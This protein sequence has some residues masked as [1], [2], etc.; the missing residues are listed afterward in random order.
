M[1]LG[2]VRSD[3]SRLPAEAP[4]N[5]R[6]SDDIQPDDS[7]TSV[8]RSG[9]GPVTLVVYPRVGLSRRCSAAISDDIQ[10]KVDEEDIPA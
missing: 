7:D 1:N 3:F 4:G 2:V 8:R 6:V 5:S 10:E 9:P